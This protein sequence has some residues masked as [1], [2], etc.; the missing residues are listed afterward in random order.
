MYL[1]E[2]DHN[3]TEVLG[4]MPL[5]QKVERVNTMIKY[6]I[7]YQGFTERSLQF[8][9]VEQYYKGLRFLV[10]MDVEIIRCGRIL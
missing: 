4:N 2:E 10:W 7:V 3:Q 9:T 5:W 8:K 1:R 6:F